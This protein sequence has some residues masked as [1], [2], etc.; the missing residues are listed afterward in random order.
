[1][2]AGAPAVAAPVK[3]SAWNAAGTFEERSFGP[4]LRG[5]L[6]E[7][8]LDARRAGRLSVELKPGQWLCARGIS[9]WGGSS[10]DIVIARGKARYVYDLHF[11]GGPPPSCELVS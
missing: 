11:A 6:K 5:R 3:G 7:L 1:M 4:W 2:D 10:A 8:L 9:G